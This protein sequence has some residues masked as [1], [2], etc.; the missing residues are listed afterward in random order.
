MKTLCHLTSVHKAKDTRIYYKECRAL[1]EA[2]YDVKLVVVNSSDLKSDFENL[3]IVNVHVPFQNK[4]TRI[5]KAPFAVLKTAIDIDADMYH[6]HDPELLLIANRLRVNGACVVYDSHEDVPNQIKHKSWIP[7]LAKSL[8][9]WGYKYFE[10]RVVNKLD[11]VVTVVEPIADR[12]RMV[13]SRVVVLKNYPIIGNSLDKDNWLQ[14]EALA[15]YIGDLT[16]VRGAKTMVKSME[17]TSIKLELG[18]SFESNELSQEVRSYSGWEKV[19]ELGFLNRER[20]IQVYSKCKVGLVLLHPTPSYIDALPVKLLEYMAA[21][22]AVIGS[23]FGLIKEIVE[24]HQCG[25][26]VNPLDEVKAGEA[27]MSFIDNDDRAKKMAENGRRAVE[28]HYN[29]Q[30]EKLKLIDLYKTL[31]D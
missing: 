28:E 6:F 3:E 9:S 8:L 10:H 21:G 16:E 12:F 31:L 26:L 5:L 11:A 13:N 25:V 17:S 15:C 7:V 30:V 20:V 2:G 24:K 4:L 22:L 19:N 23:D 14:R 1:A 29:W 18:G 27:I